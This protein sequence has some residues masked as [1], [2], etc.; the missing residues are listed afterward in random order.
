M[1]LLSDEALLDAYVKATHLGLEQ[2]FIALLMEEIN[3]RDLHVP[4]H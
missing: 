1:H 2:E 3:K 4:P